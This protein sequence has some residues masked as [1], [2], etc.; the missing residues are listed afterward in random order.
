MN[1]KFMIS[2]LTALISTM[3]IIPS[4]V[5]ADWSTDEK[6]RIFYYTDEEN[7]LTGE[8]T[9]DNEKYLFS[10][11]GVL[12]T[13]WRTVDG[14][15]K[16]FDPESGKSITGWLEYCGKIYY[17]DSETGK[18]SGYFKDSD[19]LLHIASEKGD[20]ITETGFQNF[21][22]NTYYIL[23]EGV[24]AT[25]KNIIGNDTYLFDENGKML[26]DWQTI[27]DKKYYFGSDGIML[28][29]WQ[30]IDDNEVYFMEDGSLANGLVTIDDTYYFD[31][32]G[33]KQFGWIMVKDYQCYFDENGK[34]LTGWQ[35]IDG[36]EYYFNE[37]G[38][39]QTNTTIDGKVLGQDG[40]V[41]SI[42]AVQQKAN[43][44]IE[45][46]GTSTEAIYNYV[47]NNNKYKYIEATRTLSEIE[48][49]GWSYFAEYAF[50]NRFI[51]CYYF[52]AIT[53]LLYKQ[54]GYES[55]IVYGTGRGTGDHYWNEIKIN[56]EWTSI[57]TCNG[58]FQVS[59]S[60]L[61]T[62]NY[63]LYNYVYPAYN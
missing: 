1:S 9:V 18:V 57:D 17:I 42:S 60:Y 53:D 28:T 36:D 3:F 55:R 24:L 6:G 25:G 22:D 46:I 19:G 26:T 44:I 47:R 12:K 16:Y 40:K 10:A 59:F 35:T 45:Q 58:Y 4:A 29:G 32:N 39:M 8:Q 14:Q 51:V 13:G 2:T 41:Q 56:N 15:R 48:S 21:N 52:A 11:N 30:T 31:E 61:Q 38:I 5:Y 62:Q 23:S 34:M 37:Y 33:M 7:F 49:V 27:N 63:T 43:S 20:I 54:A 50:N